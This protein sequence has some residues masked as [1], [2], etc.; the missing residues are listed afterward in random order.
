MDEED[1]ALAIDLYTEGIKELESGI[2]IQIDGTGES[3]E[4]AKR[5]KY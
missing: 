5:Y 4:K 3:Y 1:K 2:S